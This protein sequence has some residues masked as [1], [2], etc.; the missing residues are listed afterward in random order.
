MRSLIHRAKTIVGLR[1][2]FSADV[3]CCEGHPSIS[4]E[5]CYDADSC[6]ATRSGPS[7]IS[8]SCSSDEFLELS[9]AQAAGLTRY[10]EARNDG[11][12]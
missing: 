5:L 6:G 7:R 11:T 2:R 3:R 9:Y 4:S 10:W 1:H 12:S 8:E